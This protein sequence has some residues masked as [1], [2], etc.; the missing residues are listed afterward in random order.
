M[1]A[2]KKQI[3]VLNGPNLNLLGTRLPEVYGKKTLAQIVEMLEKRAGEAGYA[4][5]HIQSN[6]EGALIDAVHQAALDCVGIIINPAAYS[7][8]SIALRDALETTKIPVIEVHLSNIFRREPFR[9]HSY[10]SEV[11]TGVIVGFGGDSYVFALEA[12]LKL[13]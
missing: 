4:L 13:V 9:H 11:A 2:S 1:A 10:V 3:A 12:L 5:T 6:S 8:T 7:H